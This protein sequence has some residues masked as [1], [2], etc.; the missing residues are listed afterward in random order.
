MVFAKYSI[1]SNHTSFKQLRYYRRRYISH[2]PSLGVCEYACIQ[3][4]FDAM[5]IP[6]PIS[7]GVKPG[8]TK[9]V[10]MPILF[11]IRLSLERCDDF[12]LSMSA[13]RLSISL[14]IRAASRWK[15][16]FRRACSSCN[17]EQINNI[18]SKKQD[19]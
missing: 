8:M 15:P 16:S 19:E 17:K 18:W 9:V 14:C 4:K 10:A 1:M 12:S 3:T 7:L 13:F 5:E 2:T 6:T 11:K